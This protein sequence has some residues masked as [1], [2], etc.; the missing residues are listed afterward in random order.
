MITAGL[1]LQLRGR[2]SVH[3]IAINAKIAKE[4]KLACIS[5]INLDF[6]AILAILAMFN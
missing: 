2:Q 3:E 5:R 1:P 4:S 6:L